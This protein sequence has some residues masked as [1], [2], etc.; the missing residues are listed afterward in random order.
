MT[1]LI[2]TQINM[3]TITIAWT[4]PDI[5]ILK[6]QRIYIRQICPGLV[7]T[8]D[9]GFV[10]RLTWSQPSLP[11]RKIQVTPY[12]SSRLLLTFVLDFPSF[13]FNCGKF[14]HIYV[15]LVSIFP[16]KWYSNSSM[17]FFDCSL[18]IT[19]KKRFLLIFHFY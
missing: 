16:K 2:N 9:Y 8:N 5:R 12:V 1:C 18:Y 7:E 19:A 11:S 6:K 10:N 15:F 14:M 17:V 4:T 3:A 13:F